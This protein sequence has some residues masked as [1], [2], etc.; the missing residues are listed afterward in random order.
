MDRTLS[1]KLS[2]IAESDYDRIVEIGRKSATALGDRW[3]F[4]ASDVVAMLAWSRLG[5]EGFFCVRDEGTIVGIARYLRF[6]D[7]SPR[8]I[9]AQITVDPDFRRDGIGRWVYEQ[10]LERAQADG[11]E[12]LDSMADSR[13]KES[14]GFLSRRGFDKLVHLWTM[15]ADPDFAPQEPPAVPRGYRLREYRKGDDTALLT[16]LFNRTFDRHV[17]FFIS[18]VEDTRSIE[19]TPMFDP[20]LTVFLETE[21]GQAVAYARNSVRGDVRD[22]WVDVLGVLPE[23]QGKG[24]GRFMLLH[25]LYLLAQTR[26]KAIRLIVEGSNDRARALY[27]SEGFMEACTRI[28]Y[29]KKLA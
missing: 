23:Y 17:S 9:L 2:P 26:P 27:D 22:A 19:T 6:L 29:R 28:R 7:A 18:T 10:M 20:K 3:S 11:A 12:I 24:L 16:D 5:P 14:I 8:Q 25:S 1:L 13:D 4:T 15:Q 21:Q